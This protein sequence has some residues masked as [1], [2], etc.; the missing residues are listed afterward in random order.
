[1]NPT[2]KKGFNRIKEW[3]DSSTCYSYPVIDEAEESYFQSYADSETYE[4][5]FS[6]IKELKEMFAKRKQVVKSDTVDLICSVEVFKHK[7]KIDLQKE[8]IIGQKELPGY[9]YV[10]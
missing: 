1:M 6:N 10:F 3:V 7:P 9:V 5:D 8:T 4:L 2:E